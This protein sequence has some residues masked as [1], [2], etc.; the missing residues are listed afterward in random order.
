MTKEEKNEPKIKLL[1]EQ[2]FEELLVAEY[3][4]SG[5]KQDEVAKER[6]WSQLAAQFNSNKRMRFVGLISAVAAI[7]LMVA[8][9]RLDVRKDEPEQREKGAGEIV[10]EMAIFS[11]EEEG[12]RALPESSV[13][14][15]QTVVFQVQLSTGGYAALVAAINGGHPSLV[16][17]IQL[18][19][20]GQPHLMSK[21]GGTY[22]YRVEEED[23]TL[24][25]CIVQGSTEEEVIDFMQ[26]VDEDPRKLDRELCEELLVK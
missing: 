17:P 11:Y 2:E 18:V 5:K 3:E 24:Q 4:A 16:T 9:P 25:F 6:V 23:K 8:V 1:D 13:S 12:M 14:I 7:V 15:G 10:T 22:G 21:K 26:E 20:A 19:Q